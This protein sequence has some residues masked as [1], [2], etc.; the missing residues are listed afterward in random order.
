MTNKFDI[1]TLNIWSSF[2]LVNVGHVI[3]V[4]EILEINDFTSPPAFVVRVITLIYVVV[5]L[6]SD[7]VMM[8]AF[9]VSVTISF[10][11]IL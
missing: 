2:S 10:I 6:E 1:L 5:I 8:A 9:M 3:I 4:V 11:S 7:N